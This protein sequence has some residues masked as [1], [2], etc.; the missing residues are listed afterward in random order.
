MSFRH[1][2]LPPV[3]ARCARLPQPV[4]PS[5]AGERHID[6]RPGAQTH[7]APQDPEALCKISPLLLGENS[8]PKRQS[9]KVPRGTCVEGLQ[10]RFCERGAA[11]PLMLGQLWSSGACGKARL[12]R[13]KSA[14]CLSISLML[15]VDRVALLRCRLT[16]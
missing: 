11:T 2:R 6:R 13:L 9:L 7:R 4:P 1:F 5:R 3:F 8:P 10:G 15:V 16:L 14:R 12:V